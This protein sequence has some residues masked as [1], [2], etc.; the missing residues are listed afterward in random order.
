MDRT[1]LRTATLLLAG[2]LL[3]VGSLSAAPPLP[4]TREAEA[5]FEVGRS[6]LRDGR[7]ELAIEQFRK[8]IKADPKNPYFHKGL[9]LAL[10]QVRKHDEAVAVFRKAL[11]LNPYFVDVRNDL[12]TALILGGQREEG[13]RELLAAFNDP[14]NPSQA[15]AAVNLAQAFSEEKNL[16]EAASWYRTAINRNRDFP[17]AYVGLADVLAAQGKHEEAIYA[18]QAGVKLQPESGILRLRLGEAL[19]AVGRLAE[20]KAQLEEATRKDPVGPAG[21]RATELLQAFPR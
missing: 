4:P 6:H 7:P 21:R 19:K 15:F 10:M 12:G 18:L 8:A 9:G 14:T 3:L 13:K 1:T 16:G 20:A 11:D 2:P 5:I 17:E